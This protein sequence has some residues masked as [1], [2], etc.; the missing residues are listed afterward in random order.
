M[1]ISSGW[2]AILGLYGIFAKALH[3]RWVNQSAIWLAWTSV[4]MKNSGFS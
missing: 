1:L 4:S 3:R 2:V